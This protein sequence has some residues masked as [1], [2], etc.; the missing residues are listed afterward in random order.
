[1]ALYMS[2]GMQKVSKEVVAVVDLTKLGKI[3]IKRLV[4][5]LRTGAVHGNGL[6]AQIATGILKHNKAPII[7]HKTYVVWWDNVPKAQREKLY[8]VGAAIQMML[9]SGSS[10]P[11]S[12]LLNDSGEGSVYLWHF[13]YRNVENGTNIRQLAK[14]VLKE[15]EFEQSKQ[16]L[17]LAQA[18]ET[19]SINEVSINL[20]TGE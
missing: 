20:Y 13:S 9:S 3:Q 18:I 1:M 19:G 17:D 4:A 2:K 10:N 5:M 12:E 8:S 16:V 6:P 7:H 11:A 15:I 14:D